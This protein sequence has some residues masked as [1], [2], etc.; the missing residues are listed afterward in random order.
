M[1]LEKILRQ[2][3][4]DN[5][6]LFLKS[7]LINQKILK[8]TSTEVVFLFRLIHKQLLNLYQFQDAFVVVNLS[9]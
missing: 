7:F 3:Q 4:N 1:N 5:H 8:T 6:L 2:A 9:Y